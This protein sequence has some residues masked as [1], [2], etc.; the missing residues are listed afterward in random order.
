MDPI[1]IKYTSAPFPMRGPGRACFVIAVER[2][3][4][5][6]LSFIHNPG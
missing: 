5:R 2:A 3:A 6:T 1:S 4:Q